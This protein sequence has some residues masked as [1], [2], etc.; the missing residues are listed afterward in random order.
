MEKHRFAQIFLLISFLGINIAYVVYDVP[1]LFYPNTAFLF[2]LGIIFSA[3]QRQEIAEEQ[4]IEKVELTLT[5]TV[6]QKRLMNELEMA[7]RVQEGLLNVESPELS[8]FRI[9]KKCLPAESVGGDFYTFISK[10]FMS[11]T[12]RKK[13]TGI[14]EYYDQEDTYLGIAVG[15]VAGHG[16]SSALIMALASGLISEIGKQSHSPSHTLV[17]TNRDLMRYT[18]NSQIT[19]VTALYAVLNTSNKKLVF[20]KAGHPAALLCRKDGTIEELEAHGVILGMFPIEKFEEQ[21]VDLDSGDRVIF[22]TDGITETRDPTGDMFG[23]ERFQELIVNHMNK[24]IGILLNQTF[25]E[26]DRFSNYQKAKDDRSM[27]ILE[28]V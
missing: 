2:F 11:L 16:V 26:L 21:E 15:D 13:A 1:K 8:G 4:A 6:P 24:P 23:I 28:V 27:V 25:E 3:W 5:Q 9:A 20:S 10:D 12:P 14:T 18:E 19:H 17:A 22:Y 7:K